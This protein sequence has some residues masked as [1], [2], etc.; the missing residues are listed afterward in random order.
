[1]NS[2]EKLLLEDEFFTARHKQSDTE[3]EGPFTE[4]HLDT[5]INELTRN[6]SSKSI[7][8]APFNSTQTEMSIDE[9]S[10][11]D[12]RPKQAIKFSSKVRE[13]DR[14]YERNNNCDLDNGVYNKIDD[15]DDP[16]GGEHKSSKLKNQFD[17]F[18]GSE[19]DDKEMPKSPRDEVRSKPS[20][21]CIA[22]I[23]EAKP[24]TIGIECKQTSTS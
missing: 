18:E 17:P 2:H 16:Q 1:M 20:K 19:L 6:D 11:E 15:E 22:T 24:L 8:L 7:I 13:V 4:H 23:T 10:Y 12:I 9:I 21:R 5:S 14:Q 3:D